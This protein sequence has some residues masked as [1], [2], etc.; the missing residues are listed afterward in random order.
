M[1]QN[2]VNSGFFLVLTANSFRE[3]NLYFGCFNLI[4]CQIKCQKNGFSL[5][6]RFMQVYVADFLITDP[7][8]EQVRWI[9]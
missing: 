9:R 4:T 1:H 7:E 2:P 6:F 3:N 8:S 5:S